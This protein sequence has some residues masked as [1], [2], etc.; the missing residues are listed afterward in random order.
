[1]DCGPAAASCLALRLWA[2]RVYRFHRARPLSPG[3]YVLGALY[4]TSSLSSDGVRISPSAPVLES[5]TALADTA[6]RDPDAADVLFS[7]VEQLAT[8]YV[9]SSL[10]TADQA[11]ISLRA[12]D[13]LNSLSTNLISTTTCKSSLP[14][15]SR[16]HRLFLS[17]RSVREMFNGLE[18]TLVKRSPRFSEPSVFRRA[19]RHQNCSTEGL[20]Q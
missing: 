6:A 13:L 19:R 11:V 14:S 1:M 2:R 10:R 17:T 3:D 7:V 9:V 16:V 15:V 18:Q 12:D 8:S 20:S 4:D 5:E